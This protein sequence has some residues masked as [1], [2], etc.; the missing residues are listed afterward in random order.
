LI[1][2]FRHTRKNQISVPPMR[3]SCSS[4]SLNTSFHSGPVL[5]ILDINA[6]LYP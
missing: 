6:S 3:N 4:L 5:C 1:Y 2:L